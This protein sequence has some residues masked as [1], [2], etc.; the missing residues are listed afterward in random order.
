MDDTQ[1]SLSD[2]LVEPVVIS[3]GQLLQAGRVAWEVRSITAL[4]GT[5]D[6]QHG[7][8]VLVRHRAAFD[9]L[10]GLRHSLIHVT[11]D[12]GELAPGRQGHRVS[13]KLVPLPGFW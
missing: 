3:P 6:P 8:I 11:I 4:D 12:L 10:T 9:R 5:L 7:H 1:G 2:R 13:V